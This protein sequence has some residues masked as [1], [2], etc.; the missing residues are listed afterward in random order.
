M[1]AVL[2]TVVA[3]CGGGMASN[4][5]RLALIIGTSAPGIAASIA[6]LRTMASSD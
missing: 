2:R 5:S 6:A 4:A 3:R 1:A